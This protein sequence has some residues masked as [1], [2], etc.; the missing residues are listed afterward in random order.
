MRIAGKRAWVGGLAGLSL[1][2]SGS[3][4]AEE[5]P[6]SLETCLR[7]EADAERLACYDELARHSVGQGGPAAALA[8]AAPGPAAASTDED[9]GRAPSQS[10]SVRAEEE[11]FGL[12][13]RAASRDLEAMTA[14]VV[15][16]F[17]GWN[18]RT[19]FTLDNGQVW[20]QAGSERFRYAG[21]DRP[22]TIRR[23]SLSS[24]LLSP[25]GMKRN[26]RVRRIE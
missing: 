20:E 12:E 11:W 18:G 6:R 5:T 25:E 16:G 23:G 19:R 9:S 8:G 1:L 14:H 15:G 21:P 24:F 26:I 17:S 22:V 2:V 4:A 3:L 13:W 10:E 7:I